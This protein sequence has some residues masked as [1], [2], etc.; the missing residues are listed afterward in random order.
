MKG[1]LIFGC[2][3]FLYYKGWFLVPTAQVDV[4]LDFLINKLEEPSLLDVDCVRVKPIW[5]IKRPGDDKIDKNLDR[6]LFIE[7]LQENSLRM[8]QWVD[9]GGDFDHFLIVLEIVEMGRRPLSYFKFNSEW[10]QEYEYINK[11]KICGGLSIGSFK[12]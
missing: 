7:D 9:L 11:V 3:K 6:F 5:W 10:L 8:K 12:S 1:N 4:F 2:D